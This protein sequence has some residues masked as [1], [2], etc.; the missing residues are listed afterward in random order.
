MHD[1]CLCLKL[2]DDSII[3]FYCAG[4][5]GEI[6][7][8]AFGVLFHW[9]SLIFMVGWK[10]LRSVI[11]VPICVSQG[12]KYCFH[13]RQIKWYWIIKFGMKTRIWQ[14]ESKEC[15]NLIK[16]EC[17]LLF[18]F[19]NIIHSQLPL[20]GQLPVQTLICRHLSHKIMQFMQFYLRNRTLFPEV[21]FH[22][23][24]RREKREKEV[25]RENLGYI[26][27]YSCLILPHQSDN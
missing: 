14:V 3:F 27:G 18:Y 8:G 5:L 9:A 15:R 19:F 22:E 12:C 23:E 25:V 11:G 7:L 13:S 1:I 17:R 24:E 26:A 4:S 6:Q 16:T 20:V 2:V 21:F 10:M